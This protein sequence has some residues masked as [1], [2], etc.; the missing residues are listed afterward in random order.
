M[1][2]FLL[3][4]YSKSSFYRLS[5]LGL[6]RP[7]DAFPPPFYVALTISFNLFK[8]HSSISL[9]VIPRRCGVPLPEL[10]S[11]RIFISSRVFTNSSYLVGGRHSLFEYRF[12]TFPSS[13]ST[14]FSFYLDTSFGLFS[15]G[16]TSSLGKPIYRSPISLVESTAMGLGQLYDFVSFHSKS[17][18]SAASVLLVLRF[19]SF[20]ERSLRVFGLFAYNSSIFFSAQLASSTACFKP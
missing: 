20:T 10:V 3:I 12:S 6:A 8:S 2:L 5:F 13:T 1:F 9:S 15:M 4:R 11:E 7:H 19:P 14:F 16:S 18:S 17:V